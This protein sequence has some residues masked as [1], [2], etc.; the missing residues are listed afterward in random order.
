MYSIEE[1][2]L[3]LSFRKNN[4]IVTESWG[5]GDDGVLFRLL[6]CFGNGLGFIKP[7]KELHIL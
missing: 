4:E 1:G 5:R 3:E 2:S 6:L 7:G